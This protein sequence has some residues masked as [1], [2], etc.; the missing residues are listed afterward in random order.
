MRVL[1][2]GTPDICLP[3]LDYL[4]D[5]QELCAIITGEDKPRGRGNKLT[6]TPV[7]TWA[8][9][10]NIRAYKTNNYLDILHTEKPDIIVV[11]AYGKILPKEILDYGKFGCVNLHG[12]LLPKW[13][14]AAPIQHSIINGDK[15]TGMTA[16]KMAAKLDTGYIL[17]QKKI[18]IEDSDTA[19]SLF[20]KMAILAK[21]TL[22]ELLN[23][24]NNIT[25][26]K[27][28]DS[29]ATYASMLTKE[30]S[31]IDTN[32]TCDEIIN[33]VRGYNP[34]PVARYDYGGEIL[35]IYEA[36]KD[37]KGRSIKCSDGYIRLKKLQPPNKRIMLDT[38]YLRGRK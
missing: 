38:E 27:Q 15:I 18:A 34:S 23:S 5:N 30:K 8:E 37:D 26:I 28:D 24:I 19:G 9:E 31:Y 13:R 33:F 1:F 3:S 21:D 10:N 11:L 17:L 36:T 22:E 20:E 4:R 6:P 2:M 12:S 7:A 35:K 16:Q 32:K 25:P 14:G 29:K